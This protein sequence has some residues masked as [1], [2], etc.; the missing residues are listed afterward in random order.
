MGGVASLF[1]YQGFTPGWGTVYSDAT[2]TLD[3]LSNTVYS[4]PE[5]AIN[6]TLMV[7]ED[8]NLGI[9]ALVQNSS[10][11]QSWKTFVSNWNCSR[12]SN[13]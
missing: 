13:S 3:D 5:F 7:Q 1:G 6:V 11:P 12:C 8:S 4:I 2:Q 9:N 10:L